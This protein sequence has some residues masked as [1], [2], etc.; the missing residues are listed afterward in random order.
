VTHRLGDD[1]GAGSA[2]AIGLV[3]ATVIVTATM[4]PLYT[5]FA[6]SRQLAAAADAAALAAADTAS[7]ALPGVPC[8]AAAAAAALGGAAL[9][10]CSVEGAI[11][12]ITVTGSA[13]GM[14]LEARARAGPPSEIRS[15]HGVGGPAE[16]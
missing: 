11:A 14:R 3:A 16:D 12:T 2:L 5:A 4:L 9:A 8:E 6:S 15:R 10:D 1:T 7:G 13:L